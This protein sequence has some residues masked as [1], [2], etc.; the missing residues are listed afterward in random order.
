MALLMRNKMLAV[1]WL[2]VTPA[3]PVAVVLTDTLGDRA[4]L[5][6][7]LAAIVGAWAVAPRRAQALLLAPGILLLAVMIN[8]LLTHFLQTDVFTPNTFWRGLWVMP[9]LAWSATFLCGLSAML[10]SIAGFKRPWLSRLIAVS[11][12]AAVLIILLGRH[13]LWRQQ[14]G[15][16][17]RFGGLAVDEPEYTVAK[18]LSAQTP[19]GT[20]ALAPERVA[21]WTA[22]QDQRP[23]LIFV[24]SFYTQSTAQSGGMQDLRLR[25]QLGEIAAKG[26]LDHDDLTT[27]LA[28]TARYRLGSIVLS[29][30]AGNEVADALCNAGYEV[31]TIGKYALWIRHR[32]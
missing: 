22:V 30:T 25:N 11:F 4:Q 32:F 19:P 29:R 27:L 3:K 17:I 12:G 18:M 26:T 7:F 1:T 28:G 31:Q 2:A 14:N 5:W 10:G 23:P 6:F 13:P 20:A 24:R 8:P 21:C 15:T 9:W 16:H